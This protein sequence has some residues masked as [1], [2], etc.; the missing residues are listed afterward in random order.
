MT[1]ILLLVLV[2]L[3]GCGASVNTKLTKLEGEP[4]SFPLIR[5]DSKNCHFEGLY[6]RLVNDSKSKIGP[7]ANAEYVITK[8]DLELDMHIPD[9]GIAKGFLGF[10]L[11]PLIRTESKASYR[12]SYDVYD[13]HNEKVIENFLNRE[14]EG[15]SGG[16]GEIASNFREFIVKDAAHLLLN[17]LYQ[18]MPTVVAA[19]AERQKKREEKE[20]LREQARLT[21]EAQ[22]REKEKLSEQQRQEAE[23]KESERREKEWASMREKAE[24]AI[25]NHKL[26]DAVSVL[27][28]AR[29]SN[30]GDEEPQKLL[31]NIYQSTEWQSLKNKICIQRFVIE[32][33]L[34][35]V[36]GKF[37]YESLIAELVSSPKLSIV[38]WEELDRLLDFI[39]KSE[40][41][42]SP[43][44][45]KKQAMKKLGV[46]QLYVGSI[47]KIGSK[48]YVTVKVLNFDLLVDATFQDSAG[49]EDELKE[50]IGR[51]G[52]EIIKKI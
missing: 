11:P 9:S 49:S 14:L 37:L 3:S 19:E 23:K 42:V 47:D 44:D 15:S 43:E 16:W 22:K 4:L 30:L 29:A 32:Q 28:E 36:I 21:E 6:E 38:D 2:Q 10:Y 31:S 51:I 1:V 17:D 24:D 41:H 33:K 48:F 45:A 5:L 46:S 20:R 25:R 8:I 40:P 52:R 26:Y 12:L 7:H 13:N 39:S 34:D 35:P 27:E 18:N 50:C